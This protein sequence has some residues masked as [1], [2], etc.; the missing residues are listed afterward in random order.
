MGLAARDFTS[1]ALR[2]PLRDMYV[3]SRL[4][5]WLSSSSLRLVRRQAVNVDSLQGTGTELMN[6]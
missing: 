2:F 1:P 3:D 4:Q 6:G 5:S